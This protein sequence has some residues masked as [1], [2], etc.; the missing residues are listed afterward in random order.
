[1]I[2]VSVREVLVSLFFFFFGGNPP[3]SID[4][5]LSS[6]GFASSFTGPIFPAS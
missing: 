4:V 2:S 3:H 5:W 1:M 6:G